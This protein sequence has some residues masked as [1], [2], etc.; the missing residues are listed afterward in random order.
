MFARTLLLT[1]VVVCPL[2]EACS[3]FKGSSP[4]LPTVLI[5]R[6]VYF[7]NR[8]GSDTVATPGLYDVMPHGESGLRLIPSH[9]HEGFVIQATAFTY[10]EELASPVALA[11]PDD[12]SDYHVVLLRPGGTGL[13]AAGSLTQVRQRGIGSRHVSTSKIKDALTRYHA[14]QRAIESLKEYP[15]RPLGQND[16]QYQIDGQWMTETQALDYLARRGK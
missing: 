8:D 4:A 11:V 7:T 10:E 14:R 16:W 13:D 6:P 5:D 15:R 1:T 9:S 3:G 12:E 2:L